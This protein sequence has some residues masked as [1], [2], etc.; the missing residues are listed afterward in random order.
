MKNQ[1][2]ASAASGCRRTE[3][4]AAIRRPAT[5]KREI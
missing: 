3:R 4:A 5:I 1:K 2:I